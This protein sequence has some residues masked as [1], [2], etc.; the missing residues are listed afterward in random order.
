VSGQRID[1]TAY[2]A[3]DV[4]AIRQDA[5]KGK[6]RLTS[7]V[8]GMEFV[9]FWLAI[10]VAVVMTDVS[11]A[12]A[13]IVGVVLALGCLVVVARISRPWAYRAGTVLQALAV[14]CGFAVP[15]MF[16]LGVIFAGLW[17]VALRLGDS[18]IRRAEEFAAAI[19]R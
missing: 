4:E 5:M 9:V 14:A 16:I 3:E 17:L 11:A 10:I 6:R 19:G 12:V 13:V 1:P 18:A 15:A 7:G 2:T 8:L